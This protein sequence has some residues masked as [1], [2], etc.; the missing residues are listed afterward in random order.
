MNSTKDYSTSTAI[1]LFAQS[2][3]IESALKPIATCSEQNVL[4]WKKMN[5]KVLKIIQKTKLPYF[6]S[7]ENN[8]AGNTFGEKITHSIQEIFAK[9]FEKIIVVGNDCVALQSIHLEDAAQNLQRNSCV[10][11]ADYNG[12]VYLIGITK[13]GFNSDQ[14]ETIPW[15]TKNVFS[16]L[17]MLYKT[18]S[19]AYLPCLADCNSASDFEKALH[20]LPYFSTLKKILLSFLF[21]SK[22]QNEFETDFI[23]YQYHSSS[24]NKGSPFL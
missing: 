24:F 23:G 18:K 15:Q 19:I 10:L 5:D 22:H 13:S 12:G 9:G 8:Q 21:V 7:S 2:E 11:G 20:Q 6:I 16:A 1:L 3:K 14:F 17:Q 4:L